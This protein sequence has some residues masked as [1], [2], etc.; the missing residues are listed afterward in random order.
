MV[1]LIDDNTLEPVEEGFRLVLV[2][3]ELR[4]R[5]SLVSFDTARQIALFRINDYMDSE[6]QLTQTYV[7]YNSEFLWSE[8]L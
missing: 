4:T 1:T 6:S 7:P 8:N 3:D 5:R 2:V